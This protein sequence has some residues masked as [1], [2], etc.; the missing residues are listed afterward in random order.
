MAT[1]AIY[2]KPDSRTFQ[3]LPE[4]DQVLLQSCDPKDDAVNKNVPLAMIKHLSDDGINYVLNWAIRSAF[5]D[6]YS[7][8]NSGM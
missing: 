3:L 8:A 7:H 2:C 1:F 5:D 6:G 4:S